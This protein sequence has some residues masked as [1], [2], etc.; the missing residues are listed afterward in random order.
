MVK[1]EYLDLDGEWSH[2]G[3]FHN[4]ESAW[5]ATRGEIGYRVVP[6]EP[7]E[8]PPIPRIEDDIHERTKP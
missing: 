4:E 6:H 5:K 1:L 8:R 2:V 3:L 7:V